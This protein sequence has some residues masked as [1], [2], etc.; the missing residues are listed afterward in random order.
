MRNDMFR[1]LLMSSVL[2]FSSLAGCLGGDSSGE[3]DSSNTDDGVNKLGKVLV[4]TYHVEQLVSAV[5]G[6]LVEVNLIAPSNTPVHDFEPTTQDLSKFNDVELFFYHGQISSHGCLKRYL[7]WEAMPPKQYR[8]MLC[9]LV[10]PILSSNI[11]YGQTM[12]FTF[13]CHQAIIR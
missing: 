4:S 10:T 7:L 12:R 2:I 13:F 5:A 11:A 9:R 1:V 6:D 8:L 3:N